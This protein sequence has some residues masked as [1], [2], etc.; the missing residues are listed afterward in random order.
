MG[1]DWRQIQEQEEQQQQQQELEPVRITDESLA[2]HRE[3]LDELEAIL[4][5]LE[6]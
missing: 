4:W 1:A 5:S 2:K 3:Q 6:A